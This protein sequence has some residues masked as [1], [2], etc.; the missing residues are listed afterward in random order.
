MLITKLLTGGAWCSGDAKLCRS[1]R[2]IRMKYLHSAGCCAPHSGTA[3]RHDIGRNV[4]AKLAI[5]SGAE[6]PV[7]RKQT[8]SPQPLTMSRMSVLRGISAQCGKLE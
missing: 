7:R 5:A 6:A 1:R 8:S 4:P 2:T 3:V